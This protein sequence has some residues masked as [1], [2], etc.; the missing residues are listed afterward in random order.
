MYNLV[1]ILD[2]EKITSDYKMEIA[3]SATDLWPAYQEKVNTDNIF[4]FFGDDQCNYIQEISYNMIAISSFR[5]LT[6]KTRLWAFLLRVALF[7]KKFSMFI[8]QMNVYNIEA[9]SN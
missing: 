5:L 1:K 4:F 6:R 9:L 2:S 7:K 8:L 3:Q